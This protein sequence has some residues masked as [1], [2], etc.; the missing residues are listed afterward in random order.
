MSAPPTFAYAEA[1]LGPEAPIEV[2][3]LTV[4]PYLGLAAMESFVDR[5]ANSGSCLLVVTRF[6]ES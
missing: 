5:A 1:Y 3:A 2:D 4:H 6:I